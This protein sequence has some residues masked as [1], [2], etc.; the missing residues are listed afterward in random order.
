MSKLQGDIYEIDPREES[1]REDRGKILYATKEDKQKAIVEN[2]L[3]EIENGRPV[4][5][6]VVSEKEIQELAEKIQGVRVLKYTAASEEIFTRDRKT[7]PNEEFKNIYGVEKSQYKDYAQLI[8]TES[9][10]ENTITIGTSII[11]RGTTIK[12]KDDV[13]EKGGIHVIIDGM[14]ETSSRNQEQYKA[15]TARGSNKGSTI[16]MFCVEDVPE[17]AID[18]KKQLEQNGIENYSA[19]DVYKEVYEKV[20]SRTRTVREN[21]VGLV[22]CLTEKNESIVRENEDFSEQQKEEVVA[23]LTSRAFSIQHRACGVS[24]EGIY[25][26]YEE[27]ISAYA[28]M[29][30]A[31]YQSLN[32][33]EKN[34]DE[35]EWLEKSGYAQIAETYMPFSEKRTK[36]IFSMAGITIDGI[37]NKVQEGL[38][39]GM[40][41]GII[42]NQIKQMAEAMKTME[43]L[44]TGKTELQTEGR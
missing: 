35:A 5:I 15:R 36:E 19:D 28:D 43:I 20:D 44:E 9:G 2:A 33:G 13:N 11:G 10:K 30:V 39:N 22:N 6:G 27:E 32:N 42:N 24:D 16:E 38:E 17:A 3:S 8:K 34:F 18:I 12:T 4:L 31:K 37:K 40:R 14:H 25:D 21:V 23:L 41:S 29:Y 26:K 7:L 1:I